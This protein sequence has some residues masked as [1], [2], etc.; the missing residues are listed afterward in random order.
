[1]NGGVWDAAVFYCVLRLTTNNKCRR[2]RS[3]AL[4][5]VLVEARSGTLRIR[6]S[7]MDAVG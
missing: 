3:G 1:M 7:Q 4:L 5:S 6:R 2:N